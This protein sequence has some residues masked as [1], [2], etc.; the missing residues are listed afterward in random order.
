M[1]LASTC[2]RSGLCRSAPVLPVYDPAATDRTSAAPQRVTS[3][4]SIHSESP[5]LRSSFRSHP[6]AQDMSFAVQGEYQDY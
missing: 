5:K 1:L 4:L 3:R 6:A 2:D